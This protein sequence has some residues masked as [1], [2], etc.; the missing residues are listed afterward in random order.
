MPG[1][2]HVITQYA[3]ASFPLNSRH[4]ERFTRHQLR[5][6]KTWKAVINLRCGSGGRSCLEALLDYGWNRKNARLSLRIDGAGRIR[7][8]MWDLV[9]TEFCPVQAVLPDCGKVTLIC[10]DGVLGLEIHIIARAQNIVVIHA[11]PA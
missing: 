3:C 2:G 7:V 9:V 10:V 8:D 6:D 5:S 4:D 1:W 11:R